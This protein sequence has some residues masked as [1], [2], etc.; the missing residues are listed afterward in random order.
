MLK[1]LTIPVLCLL[2]VTGLLFVGCATQP[3]VAPEK[4]LEEQKPAV[5]QHV[6]AGLGRDPGEMYGYGAH[7]PLTRILEPLISQDLELGLKPGLAVNWEPSEDG[8]TWTIQLR[9][10]VQFHDGSPLNADAVINNLWRIAEMSPGRLGPIEKIEALDELKIKV[11][12]SEPFAP[13]LYSLAWAGS[14][15]ISPNAVNEDG[16]IEEPIGTGPFA[17]ESWTP[18]E[19][20]VM[21]RNS[22][23][24]GETPKL[25]RVTLKYIPDPSTRAM[26]LEAGEIDMIIDTGGVLPEQ[27]PTLSLNPDIEVISAAGAVPH[28][29]TLNTREQPFD[30]PQV[31]Q[32]VMYAIDPESI[33]EYALEGYGKVMNSVTP[34]S[35]QDWLHP[36]ALYQYN[37]P[38]EAKELLAQAGWTDSGNGILQKDGRKLQAKFLLASSLVGRWPYSSI[39]EIV[40]AQLRDVGMD[41]EIEV[42]EAGLW[43]ETL[44]KG[45]ANI[46][47][48]PWAGISPQSRYHE[49]LH[50]QGENSIAMGIFYNNPQIDGLIETLLKTTDD[51]RAKEL[52]Y[53]IQEIAS[54][55]VPIIP[56]Y[57][58]VIINAIR[59]NIKGY[60]LHPWF[61]IN[62]E[63]IYLE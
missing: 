32:A 40:Q 37:N 8:L 34:H 5:G 51:Q 19:E 53:Q 27:V 9:E 24:W 4:E 45:E 48:R 12:H 15:I 1:R 55:D 62:W 2:M 17:R 58:E 30:D 41:I 22:N 61:T 31:R 60:E 38:E 54:T 49:W 29:M 39:A 16:S 18:G 46:S 21:I 11:T 25:E 23:Y 43:S 42:V 57:D 26:A 13:F 52:A 6:I 56:I 59:K 14:A 44:Q 50:S 36:D 20:L 28:Y 35:E 33:I 10:N 3:A 7:P 47:M 63:D